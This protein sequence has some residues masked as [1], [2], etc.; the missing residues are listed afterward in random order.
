MAS[1]CCRWLSP[2]SVSNVG[3]QLPNSELCRNIRSMLARIGGQVNAPAGE[4]RVAFRGVSVGFKQTG[5]VPERIDNADDPRL[6]DYRQLKDAAARRRI[7]GD[8]L[9]VAEGPV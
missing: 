4:R 5:G 9:F 3:E 1:R 7:E 8:E 6:A 2:N